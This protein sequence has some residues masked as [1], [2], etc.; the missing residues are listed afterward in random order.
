M[1]EFL[2]LQALASRPGGPSRRQTKVTKARPM[3]LAKY[4]AA[5]RQN[6]DVIAFHLQ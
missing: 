4:G 1:T 6:P 5:E 2:I 3:P